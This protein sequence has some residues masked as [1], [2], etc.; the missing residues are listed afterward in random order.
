LPVWAAKPISRAK[1]AKVV[2][3]NWSEKPQKIK[4]DRVSAKFLAPIMEL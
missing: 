2:G 1:C 4:N 3:L